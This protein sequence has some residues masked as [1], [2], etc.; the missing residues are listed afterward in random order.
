MQVYHT[1]GT[2]RRVAII[3]IV[4]ISFPARA[5]RMMQSQAAAAVNDTREES[6][7]ARPCRSGASGELE[8]RLAAYSSDRP[9]RW[10]K[11]RTELTAMQRE[12]R[13]RPLMHLTLKQLQ[14]RCKRANLPYTGTKADLAETLQAAENK[15]KDGLDI[16][17]HSVRKR[18]YSFPNNNNTTDHAAEFS[19]HDVRP[20]EQ[21]VPLNITAQQA[22]GWFEELGG[23]EDLDLLLE[24]EADAWS[25]RSNETVV[26][27][28]MQSQTVQQREL[29]EALQDHRLNRVPLLLPLYRQLWQKCKCGGK[30]ERCCQNLACC[31]PAEHER[32]QKGCCELG[33]FD[34]NS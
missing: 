34:L 29:M 7:T 28:P 26:L 15:I 19:R 12:R 10:R 32:H 4:C 31:W 13:N 1:M 5:I 18:A 11:H 17:D 2:C 14:E 16:T 33:G 8:R 27:N 6:K 3:A 20:A 30:V 21:E 22:L 9:I 23:E 25:S 24:D